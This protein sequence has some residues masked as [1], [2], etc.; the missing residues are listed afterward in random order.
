MQKHLNKFTLNVACR[1][2]GLA[3]A[4]GTF[5]REVVGFYCHGLLRWGCRCLFHCKSFAMERPDYLRSYRP[6]VA[7]ET[8]GVRLGRYVCPP[9]AVH[10]LND[11]FIFHARLH[12]LIRW[13]L[14][15]RC[16][17]HLRCTFRPY[18]QSMTLPSS[19]VISQCAKLRSYAT[20]RAALAVS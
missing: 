18:C 1:G 17:A 5:K 6:V 11:P 8:F 19:L 7:E 13:R 12:R 16:A 15:P 20:K 3:V 9:S 2:P 4:A 10:F 14:T